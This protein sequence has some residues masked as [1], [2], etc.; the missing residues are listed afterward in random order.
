MAEAFFNFYAKG[1]DLVGESSGTIPAKAVNPVVVEAMK[2]K[3]ID[4]SDRKPK[5]FDPSKI[6][7]YARVISFGCLVKEVFPEDVQKRIEDWTMDDPKDKSL[8]EVRK[9]RDKVEASVKELFQ[10]LSP[11]TS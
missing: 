7:E 3:G 4:L 10:R 1:S 5:L 9:I 6:D 8:E 11:K 2:E